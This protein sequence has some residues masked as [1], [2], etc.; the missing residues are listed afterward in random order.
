MRRSIRGGGAC[1]G[2]GRPRALGAR[3]RSMPAA[4]VFSLREALHACAAGAYFLCL[5]KES[6][7][8][9][10]RL[11]RRPCGVPCAARRRG[12]SCKLAPWRSLRQ[13]GPTA[14]APAA[15]L[16]AFEGKVAPAAVIHSLVDLVSKALRVLVVGG[17]ASGKTTLLSALCHGIPKE[18][19]VVKI[20]DPEEIWLD[21]PH[22]VTLEARPAHLGRR[23]ARHGIDPVGRSLAAVGGR[24]QRGRRGRCGADRIRPVFGAFVPRSHHRA[25]RLPT[26]HPAEAMNRRR[27]TVMNVPRIANHVSAD[28]S[29]VKTCG[30][31]ERSRSFA[32]DYRAFH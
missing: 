25:T 16:G 14:P 15:L 10:S 4:A 24:Y 23:S 31:A 18:A 32:P 30:S 19:R 9:K 5:A 26:T 12:R 22:V 6:R 17:T 27:E 2:C 8:R 29:T 20:E 3:P 28:A 7:Q 21:H 13:A 11:R 1:S